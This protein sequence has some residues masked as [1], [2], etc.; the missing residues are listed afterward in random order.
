[1]LGIPQALVM[2]GTIGQGA[3]PRGLRL[4]SGVA[5]AQPMARLGEF[6][7]MGIKMFPG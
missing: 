7:G 4:R 6:V 5:R 1:M 3:A 2:L